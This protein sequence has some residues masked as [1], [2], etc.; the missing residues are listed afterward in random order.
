MKHEEGQKDGPSGTL[1]RSGSEIGRALL[2]KVAGG[3]GIGKKNKTKKGRA[4]GSPVPASRCA[5]VTDY[6]SCTGIV[7]LSSIFSKHGVSEKNLNL[8]K[9]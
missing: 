5:T 9:V 1:R 8:K 2:K 7:P 4:R 6:R 3:A